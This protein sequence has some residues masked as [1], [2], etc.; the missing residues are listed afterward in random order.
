MR[1]LFCIFFVYF[2]FNALFICSGNQFFKVW[3]SLGIIMTNKAVRTFCVQCS[4]CLHHSSALLDNHGRI[5]GNQI[6][7]WEKQMMRSRILGN[8]GT[9]HWNKLQ[10]FLCCWPDSALQK[11]LSSSTGSELICAPFVIRFL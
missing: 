3:F 7:L 1:F 6:Q 4:A 2:V 10:Q 8:E 9:V 5:L 11:T